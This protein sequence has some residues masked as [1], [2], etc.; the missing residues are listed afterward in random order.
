MTE[1]NK[2]EE[3]TAWVI[4]YLIM[5]S[6]E[7]LFILFFTRGKINIKFNTNPIQDIN[8]DDEE[9][10]GNIPANIIK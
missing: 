2:I 4:K 8:Q 9:I 7:N 5:A 6:V 1:N 10:A 3:A